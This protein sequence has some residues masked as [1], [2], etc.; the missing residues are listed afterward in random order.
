MAVQNGGR[1]I[2]TQLNNQRV[3]VF[4]WE[5]LDILKAIILGGILWYL[6][7]TFTSIDKI[8]LGIYLLLGFGIGYY[9]IPEYGSKPVTIV[10]KLLVYH[11]TPKRYMHKDSKS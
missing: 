5:W 10:R 7:T 8:E 1:H 9:E 11:L 4:L 3:K 2:I 6:L